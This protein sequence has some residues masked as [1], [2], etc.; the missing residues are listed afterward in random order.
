MANEVIKA[1]NEPETL[2]IVLTPFNYPTAFENKVTELLEQEVFK[3]RE[4]AREW[5][6]KT[7][8]VLE[9]FYEKN[10]GLF[11]VESDAVECN[12][13]SSPYTKK[14]IISDDNY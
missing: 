9:V 8:I 11:A 7:P 1:Q 5:V 13:C 10:N 6:I 12:I 4:E 14:D 3:T 2:H